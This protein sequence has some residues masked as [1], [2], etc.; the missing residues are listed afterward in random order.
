M[1]A[2]YLH[3]IKL[4]KTAA[5][6]EEGTHKLPVLAE[7]LLA[8]KAPGG[9]GVMFCGSMATGRLQDPSGW[10]HTHTHIGGTT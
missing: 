2:E 7:E 10:F 5:F 1:L 8:L 9:G 4:V 6:W 3:K